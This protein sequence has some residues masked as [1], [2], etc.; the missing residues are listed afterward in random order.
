MDGN[1]TSSNSLSDG[2]REQQR[3]GDGAA[4]GARCHLEGRRHER[5]DAEPRMCLCSRRMKQEPFSCSFVSIDPSLS[6]FHVPWLR[7]RS[8]SAGYFLGSLF[9]WFLWEI[10]RSKSIRWRRTSPSTSKRSSTPNT[11]RV[12]TALWVATSVHASILFCHLLLVL[13]P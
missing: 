6:L 1:S 7:S 4:E 8:I 13:N 11:G 12:G 2:G 10:R 5:R 9:L 3:R